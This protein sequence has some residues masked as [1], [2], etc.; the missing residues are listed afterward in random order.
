MTDKT[1]RRPRRAA[2]NDTH[3]VID[4]SVLAAARSAVLETVNLPL[5]SSAVVEYA[6]RDFLKRNAS[7]AV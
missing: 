4:T 2:K 7:G 6:V 3:I 5:S 1:V